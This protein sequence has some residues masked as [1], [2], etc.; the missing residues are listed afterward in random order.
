MALFAGCGSDDSGAGETAAD[1]MGTGAAPANVQNQGNP[2]QGDA[3]L[4]GDAKQPDTGE[5]SKSD[6]A[7]VEA[8]FRDYISA[9]NRHDGAAVCPLLAPGA[10]RGVRVRVRGE[11]CAAALDGSIGRGG[12]GGAPAWK[13]TNVDEVRAVSVG[14]DEARV[15][16]TVVH[17][18]SDRNYPS[19]EDDVVYLRRG[20]G[21]WLVVKADG[22]L[23][24]AVGYAEPPLSAFTA[25]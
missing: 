10:L 11:D 21:K 20:E 5:L 1:A 2:G 19:V 18:F 24:R 14:G 6:R 4:G 25:P 9:L 15:T 13:R 12:A 17:V 16:A 23:Y 3:V 7:A 8:T 22:A